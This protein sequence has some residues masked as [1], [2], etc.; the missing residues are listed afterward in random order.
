MSLD[1][2]EER[3][4]SFISNIEEAVVSKYHD[5]AVHKQKLYCEQLK[6]DIGS[7]GKVVYRINQH[8]LIDA[9]SEMKNDI[10]FLLKRRGKLI[11]PIKPSRGKIAGIIAYRLAKNHIIHLCEGCMACTIQCATRLNVEFA[12]RCAWNYIGINY[13]RIPS[14]VRKELF[15]SFAYRHV[16][17]ETLGL[18]F[19]TI[20]FAYKDAT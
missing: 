7:K 18:V 9:C 19:D 20:F 10:L 4:A 2:I 5:I 17:Q 3:I 16:N 1:K 6:S 13:L 8:S 12:L 15:Y 11:D 14:E